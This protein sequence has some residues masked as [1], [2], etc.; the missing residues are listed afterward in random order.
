[1]ANG[2]Q[3]PPGVA[4]AKSK[5]DQAVRAYHAAVSVAWENDNPG[6]VVGWVMGMAV[7]RYDENDVEEDNLMIESAPGLNNFM[8]RGVADAAAESFQAQ[9]SGW[10]EQDDDV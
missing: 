9:A 10:G 7:S 3:K 2:E 6:I 5:L 1:M 4:I 8:A